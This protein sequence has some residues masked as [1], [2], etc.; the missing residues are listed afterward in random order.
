M[1]PFALVQHAIEDLR[2]VELIA[3]LTDDPEAA[4]LAQEIA[5]IAERLTRWQLT[6]KRILEEKA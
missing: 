4:Y 2:R 5:E 6:V 3:L 1:T